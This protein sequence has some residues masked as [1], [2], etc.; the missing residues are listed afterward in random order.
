MKFNLIK[1]HLQ[2]L[3]LLISFGAL[4]QEVKL[5]ANYPLIENLN[6]VTGQQ[7]DAY[8]LGTPP[9]SPPSNG[10]EFCQNGIWANDSGQGTESLFTPLLNGFNLSHFEVEIEF[11]PIGYTQPGDNANFK[12]I[13]MGG[14]SG[15]W[16]G[17]LL[18][19]SGKIGLKYNN[20]NVIWSNTIISLDNIFHHG[21]LVYNNGQT[22]LYIDGQLVLNESLPE[23][24]SFQDDLEFLTA[25]YSTG[26]PFYGCVRQLK[27]RSIPP[28]PVDDIQRN[29]LVE[30]YN[31]TNGDNWQNNTNWL[32]GDPCHDEWEGI[33]CSSNTILEIELR[34][35]NLVGSIP[36]EIGNLASL[37]SLELDSNQLTGIIPSEIGNLSE[38]TRLSI[39]ANQL[40]GGIPSSLGNLSK[41]TVLSLWVNQLSGPI[42]VELSNLNNLTSLQLFNNNLT[43]NIP[44]E[45][46]NLP[47]LSVIS[48]GGNSFSGSI[49]KELAQ[50]NLIFLDI[51]NSG[52]TGGIPFE[53][54]NI[55]TLEHLALGGNQLNGIIPPCLG[56]L[57]SLERL[58]LNDAGLTG[59]IPIEL[60]NLLNLNRLYLFNNNLIGPIHPEFG[61][62]VSLRRFQLQNNQLTG[63]IPP[64]LGN[65]NQLEDLFLDSN[66][67]EGS[68]PQEI[69]NITSLRIL[70]L[71]K[72]QLTGEI[73]SSINNLVN[74]R[75]PQPGFFFEFDKSSVQYNALFTEDAALDELLNTHCVCDWSKSQT[76]TPKNLSVVSTSDSSISL[77]WDVIE[78][79]NDEGGYTIYQ[80]E[81][82]QGPY[83]EVAQVESKALNLALITGLN[84]GT[85]Y[86][87][88]IESF[89]DINQNNQNLIV[90]EQTNPLLASTENTMSGDANLWIEIDTLSD[91]LAGG[92]STQYFINLGNDGPDDALSAT[93]FHVIPNELNNVSWSC[94]AFAGATCPASSRNNGGD[95][96]IEAIDLPVG[97]SV[98]F[99]IT[100]DVTIN[101]SLSPLTASIALPN[102]IND[103]TV[104]NNQSVNNIQIGIFGS[105]CE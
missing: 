27:V 14:S 72:N 63:N 98:L 51:Q 74:L 45:L 57:T 90:S 48:I 65:L 35:N 22:S 6:D 97:S 66:Q 78:Y 49:P 75:L 82:M 13:I 37:T 102:S 89:T 19:S 25:D 43:G 73:P 71:K 92:E 38:L 88:K 52:F 91:L 77:A 1:Q 34:N 7:S 42:P 86:F 87:F 11:K 81:I 104:T 21:R 4:S 67:L 64:E 3:L 50:L 44:V 61:S 33:T 18:D 58:Y 17:I 10:V 31:S 47:N 46:T 68:I 56:G 60:T 23:L 103:T 96:I 5:I 100:A 36:T 9:P 55:P 16:I 26:S 59:E 41:L 15:R 94:E 101:E 8:I 28:T 32:N 62:L 70:K 69:G 53:L 93:L 54:C 29:A 99:T 95:D 24:V 76:L 80:S 84:I 79:L 12:A 83:T 2:I 40:S 105:G 39:R 85:E 30:L 20:A